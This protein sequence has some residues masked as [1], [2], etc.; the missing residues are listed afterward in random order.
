MWSGHLPFSR[1]NTG[2]AWDLD[3]VAH[4]RSGEGRGWGSAQLR[5]LGFSSTVRVVSD[6]DEERPAATAFTTEPSSLDVRASDGQVTVRMHA[7]DAQSGVRRVTV[8]LNPT[9]LYQHSSRLH[10]ISGT[11]QAGVWEATMPFTRCRS[12][13]GTWSAS[14]QVTDQVGHVRR[15]EPT[16]M[17]LS[18]Q[19][20][21]H[22]TPTSLVSFHPPLAGPLVVTFSE[23]VQG[24]DA[25]SMVVRR[26]L[27]PPSSPTA[28]AWSCSDAAQATTDCASGPVRTARFVPSVQF[29]AKSYHVEINPIHV[30]GV[31]DLSG[32]P[33]FWEAAEEF[34]P[35]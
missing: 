29:A 20:D 13:A 14:V 19:A 3:L 4:D 17:N 24:V 31:T 22:F 35:N 28:G 5:R 16:S 7:S 21:D 27:Y 26:Y 1:W 6:R 33:H 30:L 25:T 12:E 23:D 10:L 9:R 2:G 32:N 18:M 11:A 15:Y 8:T 34:R